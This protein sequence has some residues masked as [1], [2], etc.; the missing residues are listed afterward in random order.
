[1]F[2]SYQAVD[3][4][5]HPHFI[6]LPGLHVVN[7]VDE[8]MAL[9]SEQLSAGGEGVIVKH[10]DALYEKKRSYGWLKVKDKQTVDVP[11]VGWFEGTGKYKGKLGGLI[12]DVEGVEV[13]VGT[14]LS[15]ALRDE[16]WRESMDGGMEEHLVEVAY[17]EKTP[18]GSLRHPRFIRFR[19]GP[20]AI[21]E[22]DP[23][24]GVGV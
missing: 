20:R 3:E 15:D 23:E 11:V 1:M 16:L 14:G 10:P 21:D 5:D 22:K 8:I 2:A 24:D 9:H 6:A 13:R 18:D 7:G 19:S 17:H 4:D 12:V